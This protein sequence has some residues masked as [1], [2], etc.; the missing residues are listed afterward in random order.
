MRE[1]QIHHGSDLNQSL[2]IIADDK[3]VGGASHCYTIEP[4]NSAKVGLASI[5]FQ[6]GALR[7][8]GLNGV[9]D[10]A[11]IAIVIDRLRGF[12]SGPF[13]CRENALALTKM[14][15]ALHWLNART[16]DRM[17]RGVEGLS[18]A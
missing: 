7:E 16:R 18:I 10:E 3:G 17:A 15:E 1:I 12:Q 6:E 9:S 13:S 5:K 4:V 11:L 8:A 2:S 14:E